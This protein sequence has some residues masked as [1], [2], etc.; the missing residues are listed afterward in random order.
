MLLHHLGIPGHCFFVYEELIV[1]DRIVEDLKIISE[2]ALC[3][4]GFD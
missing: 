4:P 3:F 2:K 1:E